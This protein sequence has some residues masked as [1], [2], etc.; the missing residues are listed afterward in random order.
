MKKKICIVVANYYPNI[1]MNLIKGASKILKINSIKNYKIIKVPGIFE[2]PFLIAK[3]INQYDG[4][5]A[6]GC[7]IKGQTQHFELISKST[8]NALMKLTIT[9]K[10]P[11]GNGIIT[12]NNR[13]QAAERSHLKKNNKGEE[14]AKAVI[15]ILKI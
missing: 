8:I 7:V 5:I 3:K 9:Y 10:K 15:S 2:L 12:C 13:K 6:L 14:A 4:F 1:S 11:I